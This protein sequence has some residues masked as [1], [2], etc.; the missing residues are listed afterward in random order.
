MLGIKGAK[1]ILAIK[2]RKK[3]AVKNRRGPNCE[4][5]EDVFSFCVSS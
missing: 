2:F 1:M 5:N 3:I 4:R